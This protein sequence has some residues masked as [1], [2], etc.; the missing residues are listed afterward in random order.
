M[1]HVHKQYAQA[2]LLEPTK[3][4]RIVDTIHRRLANHQNTTMHDA[5]EVFLTD[6]RREELTSVDDVLALDNSRRRRVLATGQSPDL[7]S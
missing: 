5:F 1:K 3:L 7:I 6:S 4:R 2:F